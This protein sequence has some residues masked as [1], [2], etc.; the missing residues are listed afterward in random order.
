MGDPCHGPLAPSQTQ[1]GE[2]IA[3]RIRDRE[4]SLDRAGSKVSIASPDSERGLTDHARLD[5]FLH[6]QQLGPRDLILAAQIR[7]ELLHLGPGSS[8]ERRDLRSPAA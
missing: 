6:E 3:F 1:R 4:E 7:E 5:P 2:R 8:D